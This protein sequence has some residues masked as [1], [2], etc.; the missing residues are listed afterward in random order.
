M[1]VPG[2]RKKGRKRRR[3]MNLAREDMEKVGAR[4]GDQVDRIK[5]R[6]LS[7]CGDPEQ[8]EAERR[9]K[10][11]WGEFCSFLNLFYFY[12]YLLQI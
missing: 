8:G 2:R 6:T 9:K 10:D 1:A 5:W 3:W 7:G 12:S 11:I 4:E